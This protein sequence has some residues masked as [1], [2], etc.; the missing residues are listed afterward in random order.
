MSKL[1]N[2]L[3]LSGLNKKRA[4]GSFLEFSSKE[5]EVKETAWLS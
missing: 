4:L 5:Y 2:R 1:R 3:D